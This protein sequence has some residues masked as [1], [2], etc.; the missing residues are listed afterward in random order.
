MRPFSI[1]VTGVGN[2]EKPIVN[3]PFPMVSRCTIKVRSMGSNS[4][5]DMG[6][7]SSQEFRLTAVGDA[8]TIVDVP[9]GFNLQSVWVGGDNAANDG[10]LEVF[11]LVLP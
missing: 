3:V 8:F 11:G 9:G 4:V 7:F 6:D 5:I 2:T 1:V 10:V